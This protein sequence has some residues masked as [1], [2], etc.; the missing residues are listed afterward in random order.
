MSVFPEIGFY[1]LTITATVFLKFFYASE[2]ALI[3]TFQESSG[4]ARQSLVA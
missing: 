3:I 2:F 1:L 4:N